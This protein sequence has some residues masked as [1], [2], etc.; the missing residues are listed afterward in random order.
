MRGFFC[1]I[2]ICCLYACAAQK[3]VYVPPLTP[4]VVSAPLYSNLDHWAAHPQ[5]NDPADS[6]PAPLRK[7][8]RDTL[9]DVFFIHPTTYTER[10][11]SGNAQVTDLTLNQKTD[12]TTILFQASAFNQHAR[13]FAP[14]YR[15]AHLSHFYT[16]RAAAEP[17]FDTAYADV[18]AA[19]AYFLENNNEGRPIIIAA[20]SQGA[21]LATRLLKQYF[22]GTALQQQLVAAYVIGWPVAQ[23]SFAQLAPCSTPGQTNCFVSWRTF[24]E[25]YIPDYIEKEASPAFVTNPLTWRTD[26]TRAGYAL[27]KGSV[28]R[29]FNKIITGVADARIKGSVLWVSGLRFPG[30]FLL[31]TS[32]YH[33]GDINLFYVNIRQNV[34]ERI[35]AFLPVPNGQP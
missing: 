28:L 31:N 32:N 26:S 4:A 21:Y 30:A 9:V 15:Q 34:A 35:K 24:K 25:G 19:F 6:V 29:N 2:I 12:E 23:N 5:K 3:T 27:N 13:V 8:K 18:Q 22:D 20:H 14:R 16:D 1:S 10:G 33:I 11:G 17:Y 7:E